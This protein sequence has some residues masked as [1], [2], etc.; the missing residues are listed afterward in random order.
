MYMYVY[1]Y[2]RLY[3]SPPPSRP[4]VVAK[5]GQGALINLLKT[6]LVL[7]KALYPC[8]IM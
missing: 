1:T 6:T 2:T 3:P 4:Y 8:T 7:C 5:S